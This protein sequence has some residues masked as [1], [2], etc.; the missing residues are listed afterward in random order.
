MLRFRIDRLALIVAITELLQ[1]LMIY[2]LPGQF[3]ASVYDPI[4]PYFAQVAALFLAGSVALFLLLRYRA[5]RSRWRGFS[6]VAVAPMALLAVLFARA[7]LTTGTIV[8]GAMALATLV[9]PWLP[10]GRVGAV[11]LAAVVLG[12]V[13]LANGI[14]MLTVPSAYSGR[15]YEATLPWLWL[16]GPFGIVSGLSLLLS[17]L[18][19]R[20]ERTAWVTWLGA[21]FPAVLLIFLLHSRMWTTVVWGVW[22]IG[23]LVPES[24]IRL[25]DLHKERRSLNE[26]LRPTLEIEQ[27]FEIWTWAL[28]LVLVFLTGVSVFQQV[29]SPFRT[30]V[31]VA[32]ISLYNVTSY[33]VRPLEER[34]VARVLI[35]LFV[36]ALLL[37][38]LLVDSGPL[39]LILFTV[40]MMEVPLA[41]R[42]GGRTVGILMMALVMLIAL[43]T[44]LY[45]W[46]M[47]PATWQEALGGFIMEATVVGVAAWLGLTQSISERHLTQALH[48]SK[49]ELTSHYEELHEA[50]QNLQSA[51][52]ELAAQDEELE[53]VN[54]ALRISEERFAAL[55]KL[56]P[57]AILTIDAEQRIILFNQ[58]A[59][60]IFGYTSSEILGQPLSTLLPD[61]L[62][63]DGSAS[64][65]T[66]QMAR[67]K[68]GEM[69]PAEVAMAALKVGTDR[70]SMAIVQDVTERQRTMQILQESEERFRSA[71]DNA[72][73]GV[74]LI[75]TD[76]RWLEVNRTLV[77]MLG[78]SE[79]ELLG[80][81]VL[82][83][84][85]EEDRDPSLWQASALAPGAA[86][87]LDRRFRRKD[88]RIVWVEQTYSQVRRVDGNYYY[89]AQLQDVTE[90][91]EAEAELLRLANRDSLTGLYN[92]RRFQEELERH[93][94]LARHNKVHGAVL[95]MDLDLFKYVNDTLG[96]LAGDRVL[97]RVAELIQRQLRPTD[98]AARHGGDEFAIL[99]PFTGRE[100]VEI[101]HSILR[102]LQEQPITAE[103]RSI[104]VTGSAGIAFFPE[105]GLTAETLVARAD[106]AMYKAKESGRNTVGVFD[107]SD[108]WRDQMESKL[109]WDRRLRDAL[110]EDRFV[111]YAQPILDLAEDRVTR[112]ELLLRM[113]G[114][115][116]ELIPPAAFLAG[117]ERYGLIQEI[118]RWVLREAVRLMARLRTHTSIEAF[119]VNLSGK[120]ISDPGLLRMIKEELA[121]HEVDPSSLV[122]EITETAAISDLEQVR[123]FIEAM[124][125]LG[126]RFALDDV[127]SGFST[128]H[129][130]K[131]LKVDYLKIDGAFVRNLPTEVA[132][133]HLVRAMVAMARSQGQKTIAEYVESEEILRLLREFGV[134]YA[135]GYLVGRP[136]LEWLQPES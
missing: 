129:L 38:M 45:T 2:A 123:R 55:I 103:G 128:L 33:L 48:A 69:F 3:V 102:G 93:L 126:C 90:R 86:R 39:G 71:F 43:S 17:E 28:S 114:E 61:S 58:R 53:G 72:P 87:Q 16:L 115:E 98:L 60:Q 44:Q 12:A 133:Q 25:F 83:V 106:M 78:Y 101:A 96:H 99:M 47:G 29:T 8:Y 27:R 62:A 97:V 13:S 109:T 59:V 30:V 130:L 100:A 85:H 132:D 135:Q 56:A 52:E 31:F 40:L 14:L 20:L 94:E 57:Y 5:P 41:T 50:H 70:F 76:G 113:V 77:A 64:N 34:P 54:R 134:D 92:R 21:L 23:I 111:L 24:W 127:G 63:E 6:L 10:Q 46:L 117:A 108:E 124:Q 65:E 116:G 22:S 4:R 82:D 122:L 110:R 125:E 26:E 11:H 1:G 91:K 118:D 112:L 88:G 73:I 42:V 120:T 9:A 74:A 81:Q 105:H 119:E 66:G 67:R 32:A 136:S 51:Y 79:E 36:V 15:G 89:I 19:P 121:E 7:G 37:T 35:R 104:T 95:F 75:S 68:S 131:H 84:V 18:H 107:E 80:H 49:A